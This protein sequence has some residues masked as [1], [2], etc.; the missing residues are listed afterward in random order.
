MT[1]LLLTPIPLEPLADG[2]D[3]CRLAADPLYGARALHRTIENEL[4]A[5]ILDHPRGRF[6]AR[7][8][9]R[10]P[11]GVEW[12]AVEASD[13]EEGGPDGGNPEFVTA[14]RDAMGVKYEAPEDGSLTEA[15]LARAL[16]GLANL[17]DAYDPVIRFAVEHGEV[18]LSLRK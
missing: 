16:F 11:F 4:V 14:L 8:S 12:V 2:G 15:Q 1:E 6:R 17:V 7:L 18:D 13:T 5:R 10:D 9:S 3:V